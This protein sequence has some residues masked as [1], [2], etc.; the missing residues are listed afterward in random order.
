ML[1]DMMRSHEFLI[2]RSPEPAGSRMLRTGERLTVV[3]MSR[4]GYMMRTKSKRRIYR[5]GVFVITWLSCVY[6]KKKAKGIKEK[7]RKYL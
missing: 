4:G 7:L 6:V 1:Q 5:G 2:H 3:R